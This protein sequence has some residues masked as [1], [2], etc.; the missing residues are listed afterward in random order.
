M[1]L[2]IDELAVGEGHIKSRLRS[3]FPSLSAV[4]VG[5]FPDDLKKNWE[6]IIHRLTKK[7]ATNKGSE[8]D[9]GNFEATIFCMHKQTAVKIATDIVNIRSRLE[10]HVADGW[11]K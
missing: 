7:E 5:D 10:D 3:V 4:S 1:S 2:A 9:E 6:S 11:V 8:Y